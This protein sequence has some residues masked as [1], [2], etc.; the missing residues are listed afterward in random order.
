M[1]EDVML[2]WNKSRAGRWTNGGDPPGLYTTCLKHQRSRRTRDIW[3]VQHR[4]DVHSQAPLPAGISTSHR[5][6]AESSNAS[7]QSDDTTLHQ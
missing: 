6:A 4:S 2:N 7:S 3:M 5:R 1:N